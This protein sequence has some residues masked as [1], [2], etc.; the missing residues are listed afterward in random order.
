MV[1]YENEVHPDFRGQGIN[2]VTDAGM[3]KYAHSLGIDRIVY[4]IRTHN[5]SSLKAN[6]SRLNPNPFD[7]KGEIRRV[8]LFGG[9][10]DRMPS[11]ETILAMIDAPTDPYQPSD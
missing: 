5:A 1:L 9:L 8:T 3:I 7:I 10:I 4:V 6:K 2:D 11:P